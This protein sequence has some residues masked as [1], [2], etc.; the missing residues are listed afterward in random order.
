MQGEGAALAVDPAL[1]WTVTIERAAGTPI[2]QIS[3]VPD[4]MGMASPDHLRVLLDDDGNPNNGSPGRVSIYPLRAYIRVNPAMGDYLFALRDLLGTR[5]APT[6]EVLHRIDFGGFAALV[7]AGKGEYL[8][9]PGLNGVRF[10]GHYSPDESTLPGGSLGYHLDGISADGLFYV[11][12]SFNLERPRVPGRDAAPAEVSSAPD[13][14][15]AF[16][17]WAEVTVSALPN[18]QFA[19]SLT[20]LDA[21]VRS[22]GV[23]PAALAD[24]AEAVA[25]LPPVPL[26]AHPVNQPGCAGEPLQ[27]GTGFMTRVQVNA[28]IY[29]QVTPGGADSGWRMDRRVRPLRQAVCIGRTYWWL[30]VDERSF[31]GWV[32]ETDP[33]TGAMQLRTLGGDAGIVGFAENT[34]QTP[35]GCA[36][37]VTGFSVVASEISARPPQEAIANPMRGDMLYYADALLA[38]QEGGNRYFRLVPGAVNRDGVRW[39]VPLWVNAGRVTPSEG[40][41]G[42]AII[43]AP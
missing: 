15:A 1:G 8:T 30:V 24:Y 7:M 39:D 31:S 33:N 22:I 9:A 12:A 20:T 21:I 35:T 37:L 34:T 27:P 11:E 26:P 41:A 16:R 32:S 18:D 2:D 42:I 17:D 36:L 3:A 29:P 4:E 25:A 19:P 38:R 5:A 40:C 10:V 14:L 43:T 28:L 23:D 13:Y 6:S